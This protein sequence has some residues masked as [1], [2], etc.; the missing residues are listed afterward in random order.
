MN[1][2]VLTE[3]N[4][5]MVCGELRKFFWNNNK[6]GFTNRHNFDCGWGVRNYHGMSDSLIAPPENIRFL[7]HD[8]DPIIAI[9]L[10][11]CNGLA[12]S[13][14]DIVRFYG[15]KII[16]RHPWVRITENEPHFLYEVYQAAPMSIA[17]QQKYYDSKEDEA[18]MIEDEEEE[19]WEWTTAERDEEEWERER[20]DEE[21]EEGENNY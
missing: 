2:V 4:M 5:P 8:G 17:E 14:G 11:K 18:R 9:G 10:D 16:M 20:E 12:L 6:T 3:K 13:V 19:D 7:N 1:K 21:M 15:N